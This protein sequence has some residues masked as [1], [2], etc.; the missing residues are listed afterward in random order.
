M[1][2]PAKQYLRELAEQKSSKAMETFLKEVTC[3]VRKDVI[4]EDEDQFTFVDNRM[5]EYQCQCERA[6]YLTDPD[7]INLFALT[8]NSMR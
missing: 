4:L 5:R 3:G 1:S 6:N 2:M 8:I 7:R